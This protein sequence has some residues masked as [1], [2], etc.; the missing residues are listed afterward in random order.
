MT[1]DELSID[2]W[3]WIYEALEADGHLSKEGKDKLEE[4]NKR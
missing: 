2:E 4:M 1:L 3:I